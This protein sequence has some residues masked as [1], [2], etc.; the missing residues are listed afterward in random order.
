MKKVI[1]MRIILMALLLS[2]V[3]VSVFGVSGRHWVAKWPPVERKE[4]AI[5]YAEHSIISIRPDPDK[6]GAFVETSRIQFVDGL[7]CV[8]SRGTGI[9]CNWKR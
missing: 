9:T 2:I 4:W 1:L 6:I 7:E 8:I 3:G 5:K